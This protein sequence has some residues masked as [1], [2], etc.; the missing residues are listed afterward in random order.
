MSQLTDNLYSIDAIKSGIRSAIEEKGVDM[1]GV[2]FPDYPGA[3]ASISTAF[4]TET[5]SVS[6]NG[7]Y[8]PGV[9]IDGYS[10]VIVDVPQ[11]ATGYSEKD[12]TEGT[13]I[14]ISNSA[15]Y[16][17][18]YV[19]YM[20][21]TI[22]TVNLPNCTQV[23]R[24]AFGYTTVVSVNLPVCE[25]IGYGGFLNCSLLSQIIL[26]SCEDI[27]NLAFQ[28]C[29]SLS[30]VSLPVCTHIGASAFEQCNL[31]SIVLPMVTNIE[32]AAFRSCSM[33][34]Q[35]TLGASSVC[36]ISNVALFA[37]TLITSSTGS[38]YVPSSLVSDY[39]TSTYWSIY[40]TQIFSIPE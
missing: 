7:T 39:Q 28:K 4:V 2:S 5:L 19:F 21:G 37:N 27:G 11:S 15:S 22:Q 17:G 33:L 24:S 40:S 6:V 20:N 3:I 8:T 34:S 14:N 18:S 35:I 1:T 29:Y 16:V 25:T 23:G 32:T 26:P 12:F 9:G 13:I 30:E 10:Q 38:I 31:S 36:S